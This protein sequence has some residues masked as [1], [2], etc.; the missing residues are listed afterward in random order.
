[1]VIALSFCVTT[2]SDIPIATYS[3]EKRP[4][5]RSLFQGSF[6]Y[7]QAFQL[8]LHEISVNQSEHYPSSCLSFYLAPGRQQKRER[9][10]S[11]WLKE[12]K[13]SDSFLSLCVAMQRLHSLF[14]L[15]GF[16][17]HRLEFNYPIIWI[18]KYGFRTY[19]RISKPA[20]NVK[21]YKNWFLFISWNNLYLETVGT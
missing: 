11:V 19:K 15:N 14:C 5:L 6:W 3:R 13:P 2:W 17:T 16:I 1:M 21:T 7:G 4:F 8:P 20:S 10:L 12:G 9:N 18:C